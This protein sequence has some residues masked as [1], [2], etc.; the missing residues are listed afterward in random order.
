MQTT[1]QLLADKILA[2]APKYART[3]FVGDEKAVKKLFKKLVQIWHP[4]H[5]TAPNAADVFHH[6]IDLKEAALRQLGAAP[7]KTGIE[8]TYVTTTG[9]ES[10]LTYLSR[11]AGDLGDILIASTSMVYELPADYRDVADA[12]EQAVG[13]LRYA[14]DKMRE[15]ISR[16]MPKLKRRLQLED[17][18]VLF[19][20]RPE[21][22]LLLADLANHLDGKVPA[23][24]VAWIVSSLM[25]L[26]CYLSWAGVV[27]GAI[28][29]ET[30]LVC[31]AKHTVIMVGGW[32]YSTPVGE[33]PKVLPRRTMSVIPR[34]AVKGE[35]ATT[36][37]DIDLIKATAQEIL[38]APGGTGLK[39]MTG[40]P[41]PMI[42][43]LLAPSTDNTVEEYKSWM[44]TLHRAFGKRRFVELNVAPSEVYA[45]SKA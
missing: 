36:K 24:H 10:R 9:S 3:L 12:E 44:E 31:P 2:V 28:S 32:G 16:Y 11:R 20:E 30:L 18:D 26:A 4:D 37:V 25:N 17:K 22:T 7:S 39:M 23:V 43:W 13:S 35:V 38:G 40:I 29:P 27:H 1:E 5:N 6:V 19:F 8:R 41:D 34:L 14:D 21:D 33:R 45:T 42:D 15:E